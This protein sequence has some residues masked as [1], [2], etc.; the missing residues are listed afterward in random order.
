M[1]TPDK[2]H[3]AFGTSSLAKN[4]TVGGAVKNLE[5]AFDQ[6]VT[7]FD[8]APAY[9]F[10]H[11]EM[12]L[13]KFL[14]TRRQDVTVTTKFGITPKRIPFV[15][16]PAFNLVRNPLKKLLATAVKAS[17]SSHHHAFTYA[18]SVDPQRLE[19][20]L[21]NSLK[22]LR[23]DYVDHYML[24]R[25]DSSLANQE[26]VT[27]RLLRLREAGKLR[28][29][30]LAGSFDDIYAP[31]ALRSEYTAIQFGDNLDTRFRETITDDPPGRKYF[32][33]GVFSLM[34]SARRFL[35]SRGRR[36]VSPVELCMAYFKEDR[37]FGFTLFS[38]SKNENIREV[39]RLWR[40]DNE[41]PPS[42]VEGF[43]SFVLAE[44]KAQT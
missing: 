32:R 16:M 5:T 8:T 10:G 14:R 31:P 22:E 34:G 40:K 17:G 9:C 24:H 27:E 28:H 1:S 25:I 21:N 6:G 33:F 19:D 36:D 11:A 2:V 20:S 26:D 12:L 29:F 23:T 15:L 18:T 37:S 30:G 43:Q 35:E 7:H 13:G 44:E 38:S 41:L 39:V 42:V 3:L 4:N